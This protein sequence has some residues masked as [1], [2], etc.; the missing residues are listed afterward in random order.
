MSFLLRGWP[1]RLVGVLGDAGLRAQ[2]V[3]EFQLDHRAYMALKSQPPR[4][5]VL[6]FI[7]RSCFSDGRCLP[8][9]R[10]G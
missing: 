9:V 2:V 5:S 6:N 10:G 3:E 7:R 8:A 1:L 4:R